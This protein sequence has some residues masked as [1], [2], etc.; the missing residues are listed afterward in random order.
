LGT[1]KAET[2]YQT[3][4]SSLL[5]GTLL[6][7]GKSNSRKQNSRPRKE[8]FGSYRETSLISA[9]SVQSTA[10]FY[11]NYTTNFAFFTLKFSS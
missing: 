5:Q 2:P 10:I 4:A 11:F 7:R 3:G 6:D 1:G 8:A 9:A